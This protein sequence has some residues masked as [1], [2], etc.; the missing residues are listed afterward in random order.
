MSAKAVAEAILRGEADDN[1]ELLV[2]AFKARRSILHQQKSAQAAVAMVPGTRARI[3]QIS[4]QY[5]RGQVGTVKRVEYSRAV[6][7]WADPQMV[8]SI[9]GGRFGGA[10]DSKYGRETKVPLTCLEAISEEE[11]QK[12]P[13]SI[14]IGGGLVAKPFG[15]DEPGGRLHKAEK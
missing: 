15:N 13:K 9:S 4:P 5:L 14:Q 3:T 2:S 8:R 1:I 11:F 10:P 7:E 6:F 12:T